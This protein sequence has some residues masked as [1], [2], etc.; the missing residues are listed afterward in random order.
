[1]MSVQV[2]S[3]RHAGAYLFVA[4]AVAS[5]VWM[6]AR[7]APETGD[8]AG[9]PFPIQRVTLSANEVSDALGKVDR[10]TLVRMPS[11]DFDRLLDSA[12]RRA[13]AERIRPHLV[14]ARYKARLQ[15]G[16][17]DEAGLVGTAEWKVRH[18]GEAGSGMSLDAF[19]LALS[20]AKWSDGQ[21]A[22]LY[23]LPDAGGSHLF[24]PGPGDRSLLFDWSCR[25]VAEPDEL[26]F[27]F[28]TAAAG[29]ASLDLE[30]PAAYVPVL[31][32][33]VAV[34]SGPT[35]ADAGWQ[36]WRIA[37]GGVARLEIVVRR[38]DAAGP[39]L[40]ARTTSVQQLLEAGATAR[41]EF[42][43]DCAKGGVS[44]LTFEH[45]AAFTPA[46]VTANNLMS[47]SALPESNGKGRLSVR[48]REP[49]RST[50][51]VLAGPIALP[52]L[53][54]RW[55][56]PTASLVNAVIRSEA[57]TLVL[58]PGLRF[59]DFEPGGFRLV[60]GEV[61]SDRNFAVNLVPGPAVEGQAA[62]ARPSA[63]L[64]QP[65]GPT[66]HAAQLF[67]IA[68][69]PTES[70]WTTVTR[71]TVVDGTLR[72]I[73]FRVPP[74]WA[75]E[76]AEWGGRETSW[77]DVTGSAGA[78]AV[79][80]SGPVAA[81]EQA[82]VSIRLKRPTPRS[83]SVWT[84][85]N[86]PDLV[87]LTALYRGGKISIRVDSA[88]DWRADE[89]PVG[90]TPAAATLPPGEWEQ[91][92]QT[93][94]PG[95]AIYIRHRPP[96]YTASVES[97]V[98]VVGPP[99]RLWSRMTI[100]PVAGTVST[101]KLWT[102]SPVESP[103]TWRTSAGGRVADAVP[104]PV[105]GVPGW[106][107]ALAPASPLGAAVVSAVLSESAGQFW[108][109]NF[110]TPMARETALESDYVPAGRIDRALGG[111]SA[112]PVPWI[113]GH[114]F[115]GTWRVPADAAPIAAASLGGRSEIVSSGPDGSAEFR[116]PTGG[117]GRGDHEDA[118]I[119]FAPEIDDPLL[120][121]SLS[122]DGE[123][124][125]AFYCRV[126]HWTSGEF[127]LRLPAAATLSD[128]TVASKVAVP[129]RNANDP[130]LV[131]VPVPSG[132]RWTDIR[133][134]YRLPMAVEW[135]HAYG[136]VE[137]PGLPMAAPR[138][139]VVWHVGP[140]WAVWNRSGVRGH[141]GSTDGR[142]ALPVPDAGILAGA[143]GE[144]FASPST[145]ATGP[146]TLAEAFRGLSS[147][148]VTI[149]A[150]AMAAVGLAPTDILSP[151][152][153]LPDF[154][155]AHDLALVEIGG[156]VVLT[157]TAET[158]ARRRSIIERRLTPD[159]ISQ[160]MDEAKRHGRDATGRFL[161]VAEWG[162]RP[163]PA[164]FAVVAPLDWSVW[165][166][167]S[168]SSEISPLL[169]LRRGRVETAAW[170][171]SCLLLIL[172]VMFGSTWFGRWMF[173]LILCGS[174]ILYAT[175]PSGARGLFS[176]PFFCALA[177]GIVLAFQAYFRRNARTVA[178]RAGGSSVWRPVAVV[179]VVVAA[180]G[181]AAGEALPDIVYV[182]RRTDSSGSD[183]LATPA[184]LERLRDLG[185]PLPSV[186]LNAA[187]YRGK[188]EADVASV[189][190]DFQVFSFDD[191]P[192]RLV[193]PLIGGRLRGLTV[194]GSEAADIQPA[195]E[196]IAVTIRGKGFHALRAQF[197]VPVTAGSDAGEVKFGVPEVH[198]SRF[199]FE[200]ANATRVRGVNRRGAVRAPAAAAAGPFDADWGVVSTVHLRWQVAGAERPPTIRVREAAVWEV[201]PESAVLRAAYEYRIS[202]GSADEVRISVP[203]E[204]EVTR[205]EA[206]RDG[207]GAAAEVKNWQL[208]PAA[209]TPQRIL[210]VSFQEPMT[211][212]F[213][214]RIDLVPNRPL[215]SHPS[216]HFPR[217]V[218]VA[219]S[220]AAVAIRFEGY[221]DPPVP[222]VAGLVETSAASFQKTLW[223]TLSDRPLR[224]PVVQAYRPSEAQPGHVRFSLRL[225]DVTGLNQTLTWGL[226]SDRLIG[227]GVS[228]WTR[229]NV[230]FVEW[231]L[232]ASLTLLEVRGS[233]V[234]NWAHVGDRVQVWFEKPVPDATLEWR[235]VR[236]RGGS[237]DATPVEIPNTAPVSLVKATTTHRLRVAPGWSV[238]AADAGELL[239]KVAP[240]V[241]GEIAWQTT[242]PGR[243]ARFN[244]FTPTSGAAFTSSAHVGLDGGRLAMVTMIDVSSLRRDRPHALTLE[245]GPMAEVAI[246]GPSGSTIAELGIRAGGRSGEVRLP[247]GR[248]TDS[249]EVT[250]RIAVGETTSFE[251]R[252]VKLLRGPADGAEMRL[253]L[254]MAESVAVTTSTGLTRA[255]P[256]E[257]RATGS[258]WRATVRPVRA[259]EPGER[260]KIVAA[261]IAVAH[262][263]AGWIHRGRFELTAKTATA[264]TM[265]WPSGAQPLAVWAADA[266][267]RA[268]PSLRLETRASG[269]P[270][271]V[272]VLWRTVVFDGRA[273]TFRARGLSLDTSDIE[274]TVSQP[275]GS[276]IVA[277]VAE[278]HPQV[279]ADDGKEDR[280]A[281]H[282]G[283]PHHFTSSAGVPLNVS[284]RPVRPEIL[285]PDMLFNLA[286]AGAAV[287]IIF[288]PRRMAAER[289][290]LLGAAGLIAF[291]S[292][293]AA[294]ALAP[295]VAFGLRLNTFAAFVRRDRRPTA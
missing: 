131:E 72:Q 57:L 259:G 134:R 156:A 124:S 171:A 64:V 290:A 31:T 157:S 24:V 158:A 112:I 294:F 293:G 15:P 145:D 62:L 116:Y 159:S 153:T 110:P 205:V 149:D 242:G 216:L 262:D 27:D 97:R 283:T 206:R 55:T 222:E 102:N 178:G 209:D 139:R 258:A 162:G 219:E 117:Q 245:T 126:R 9:D 109:L 235:A 36:A 291:G 249:V 202:G 241:P 118:A 84:R 238:A 98:L 87:P 115:A 28:P 125:A 148:A 25:G 175:V 142:V 129:R 154:L 39:V 194:D 140:H 132:G 21:D 89:V 63:T 13:R 257:Y 212:R 197:T 254:H 18:A 138:T 236:A 198:I 273:P 52:G 127:P 200:A 228:R 14:E 41:F 221:A 22:V 45:D 5:G 281:F 33:E 151:S 255:G 260:V 208:L 26:R 246:R 7:A 233:G 275:A 44:D 135:W 179:L 287:L 188:V 278:T 284:I 214:V 231:P 12:R 93:E 265:A 177:V 285:L 71:A 68:I 123:L 183:I 201:S 164:D 74:E 204:V 23:K 176:P 266:P 167:T 103:W 56:S 38:S 229:S 6:G 143:G 182:V 256:M 95:D 243:G 1:M 79:A 122:N 146:R 108:Q 253:L 180:V 161:S 271:P 220:D 173:I 82:V 279:D 91:T 76:R 192:A 73:V 107:S 136:R 174:A 267:Q 75:V 20:R 163:Y 181:S 99:G 144:W 49:T 92:F 261:R 286:W 128:V 160:A 30:L 34:L 19:R 11:E 96:E 190:A 130:R 85:V 3:M 250:E 53:G 269:D 42:Q 276:E 169:V 277:G 207:I 203:A 10:G 86:L 104:D 106:L 280:P 120:I 61:A 230:S 187:T 189:E 16:P 295:L 264:V 251:L 196:G 119:D 186:V 288:F 48:L 292:A 232:P 166:E 210:V 185:R 170:V 66:W 282:R 80:A 60:R 43:I 225:P 105:A 133:V 69:G 51:V 263:D 223:P 217:A 35:P 88:F 224:G 147:G 77:G 150:R 94:G 213:F 226:E 227:R 237:S 67:E 215:S 17:P 240:L 114:S 248:T 54:R 47:W 8:V 2:V 165:E 270:L 70:T 239:G 29:I 274:W 289:M 234:R 101:L 141:P 137:V 37:F 121:T 65:T 111:R 59:Q 50:S 40:F 46:T 218:G 244:V 191:R 172:P 199:I 155:A 272:E 90:P 184:L 78:I 168:E 193:I 4:V 247:A 58:G 32:P 195:G 81:G 252:P 268:G 211:G 83:G 100:R 113:V 152:M